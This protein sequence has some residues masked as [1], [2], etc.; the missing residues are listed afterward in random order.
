MSATGH[1]LPARHK[2]TDDWPA[3]Q[4]PFVVTGLSRLDLADSG[5]IGCLRAQLTSMS[6][7]P[8]FRFYPGAYDDACLCAPETACPVCG[9]T[10]VTS[11]RGKTYG[12]KENA[13][14]SPCV[15]CIAD[16]GAA[17]AANVRQ[18]WP[19]YDP[20]TEL[21]CRLGAFN[22]IV[23][24]RPI[25]KT[26]AVEELLNRTPRPP[27]W[28]QFDWPLHHGAPM[29]FEGFADY[30]SA[31]ADAKR[32]AALIAACPGSDVNWCKANITVGGDIEVMMFRSADETAFTGLLD[33]S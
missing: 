26:D 10:S 4:P 32:L 1:P 11:Y 27:T 3:R 7:M 14:L 24:R 29:I 9:R 17:R 19:E 31:E 18:D 12:T 5:Q 33:A 16:G 13:V 23:S 28:Q 2:I 15:F 20:D 8:T 30:P 21:H 22:S 25:P 6:G